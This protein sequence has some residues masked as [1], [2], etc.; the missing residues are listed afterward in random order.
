MRDLRRIKRY[1]LI[2]LPAGLVGL[3][4]PA[5]TADEEILV[6]APATLVETDMLNYGPVKVTYRT[7]AA[8]PSYAFDEV[9]F[10]EKSRRVSVSRA[11]FGVQLH[12]RTRPRRVIDVAEVWSHPPLMNAET[13]RRETST[14]WVHTIDPP[15]VFEFYFPLEEF[16]EP[17]A[18]EWSLE[19]YLVNHD[20]PV[21]TNVTLTDDSDGHPAPGR[22]PFFSQS[23]QVEVP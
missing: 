7:R 20:G 8:A 22:K 13:G 14:A 12:I 11:G 2:G 5:W 23:F 9:S 15:D 1:L 3:M 21:A 19:L 16:A 18:G 6:T 17:P 10:V 4:G